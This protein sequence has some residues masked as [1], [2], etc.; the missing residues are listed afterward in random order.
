M[1]AKVRSILD[2]YQSEMPD[3]AQLKRVASDLSRMQMLAEKTLEKSHALVGTS[4]DDRTKIYPD[5]YMVSS[6]FQDKSII[7]GKNFVCSALR[8]LNQIREM[9]ILDGSSH[10]IIHGKCD[11]FVPWPEVTL[12]ISLESFHC[13][14]S[15]FCTYLDNRKLT[16][17]LFLLRCRTTSSGHS[18]AYK[19]HIGF[20]LLGHKG[21]ECTACIDAASNW[22][23]NHY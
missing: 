13:I 6:R 8:N 12:W 1:T 18:N 11:G 3:S 5:D 14:A 23:R 19:A 20:R 17:F 15:S 16:T 2:E 4:D 22:R 21:N 9:K 7:V 10:H